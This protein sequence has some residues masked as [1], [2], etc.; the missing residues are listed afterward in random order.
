MVHLVF[1]SLALLMGALVLLRR[2]GTRL[3]RTIGHFYFTSMLGL[4]LSSQFIHRLFGGFGPFHV[5]S[6]ISLATLLSGIVA[7]IARR[8]RR[9]WPEVHAIFMSWSYVGLIA[10]GVSEVTTRIPGWPFTVAVIIPSIIVIGAGGALIH[11]RLQTT[12]SQLPA[13]IQ[14]QQRQSLIDRSSG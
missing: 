9:G 4:N 12:F 5:M 7:V 6:L 13:R 1:A 11:T 3:H 10:A 8:P 14:R 2:K